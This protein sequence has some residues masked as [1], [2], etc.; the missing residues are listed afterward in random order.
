MYRPELTQAWTDYLL[1][2]LSS[3]SCFPAKG[4]RHCPLFLSGDHFNFTSFDHT[5]QAT[6]FGLGRILKEK[7][8]VMD[9]PTQII[10]SLVISAAFP[11]YF[12]SCFPAKGCQQSTL[13]FSLAIIMISFL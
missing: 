11:P 5:Y 8:V 2:P 1:F 9:L 12:K 6:L 7:E 4:F 10:L 13:F 3:H